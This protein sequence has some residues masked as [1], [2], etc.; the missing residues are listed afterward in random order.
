MKDKIFIDTNILLYAYST[1]KNKQEI[2][3]NII[4]TNNN[5][6]IS[7]QV[8]NETIN[9]LIKK[10]KLNIKDIIN[11]VK[12]LEKEF[13]ILDFDIQTQLNALKLK[14]N[15]NLQFYDALIV[16]TALKNSC[17]ILYSEDMQDKLVIEKKLK[18][19]N[20]F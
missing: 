8:I 2:A 13:I 5:I 12:E 19:I 18:I 14:Q 9:I 7:K 6:Y 15:Y 16:S 3:Q 4:N 1:E 11:V 17:T 20:P 10:F